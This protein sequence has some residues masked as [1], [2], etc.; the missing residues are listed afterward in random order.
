MRS[1]LGLLNYARNYIPN[2][3]RLLSPLYAKTNPTGDK[4][5]NSQDWILVRQIKDIVQQ[6]PDLEVPPEKCYIILEVD[7]CM[8]G[9]GSIC[10]WKRE[11]FN[12]K[13]SEKVCAYASGKFSPIKSTI[14]VEIHA[15]MNSLE[16]LRIYYLDKRR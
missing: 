12:P 3:G 9:S 13:S 7:G 8:E 15:V 10:K 2:L 4:M 5:M 6:L 14:D 16:A 1:W 11:K